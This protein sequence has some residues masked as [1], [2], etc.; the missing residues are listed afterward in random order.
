[1]FNN[2][3]QALYNRP[4]GP[5]ITRAAALLVKQ[6]SFFEREII[7]AHAR[8]C[9]ALRNTLRV[10]AALHIFISNCSALSGGRAVREQQRLNP[11]C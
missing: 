4:D 6:K 9:G 5:L 11:H 8:V 7:Q 1:M 2:S 3:T 10:L